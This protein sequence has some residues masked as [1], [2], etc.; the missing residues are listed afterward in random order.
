MA[1]QQEDNRP[2]ETEFEE[3]TTSETECVPGFVF[4]GISLRLHIEVVRFH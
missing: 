3:A 2:E 4:E 1:A